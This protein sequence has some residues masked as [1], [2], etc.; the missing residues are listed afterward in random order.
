MIKLSFTSILTALF[1]GLGFISGPESSRSDNPVIE[2]EKL[3]FQV[4]TV[5]SGLK[6]PWGMAF[7]PDGDM[8]FTERKG[9][10]YRLTGEGEKIKIKG[11]PEVLAKSQGGLFDLELHPDYEENGWI[12]LSYAAPAEKGEEGEGANTKFIRA[13]L[14]DN[15]LVDQ[16]VIFKASPNYDTKHHYG[17]RIEFDNDGYLFLSVGDRGGR[18]FVQD[19][20]N[21][22]GKIFRLHDD[23]SVPEDNPY[24][25]VQGARP[26]IFTYGHRNPQGLAIHP[27]TGEIWETEHGPK[28]GD[29][30]N[31]IRKG[32]NYGWPVITY[33]INYNG[34][35]ITE[36]TVKE[37][38]EQPVTFWR[39][40]IAPCGIDFVTSDLYGEWK[41]NLLVGSMSF[42]YLERVVIEDDKV[43]HKEKLLENIGRVRCVRQSPDGYIYVAIEG[44]GMIVRLKPVS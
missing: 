5:V 43:V 41:G 19:L 44:P 3:S 7:L 29:E 10:L 12:Y 11:V 16:E 36:D 17:G 30:L 31:I 14:K 28:G 1:M 18:D 25:N 13:K 37:G 42:R 33:G 40:S 6:V 24:V 27:E 20:S 23:G 2:S 15:T 21:N 8:L 26:E 4:D 39:P 34:T 35:I 9:E 22:R 32:N 38:M